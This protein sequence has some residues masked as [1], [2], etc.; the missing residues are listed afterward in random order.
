MGPSPPGGSGLCSHLGGR[1]WAFLSHLLFSHD[2]SVAPSHSLPLLC[3]GSLSLVLV[4]H[5]PA[6][7]LVLQASCPSISSLLT[8]CSALGGAPSAQLATPPDRPFALLGSSFQIQVLAP[9]PAS[10]ATSLKS[11][12]VYLVFLFSCVF[13]LLSSGRLSCPLGCERVAGKR[14]WKP[15]GE[16]SF[17]MGVLLWG[18]GVAKSL[19]MRTLKISVCESQPHG[20]A[21][22]VWCSHCLRSPG[23]IPGHRTTPPVCQ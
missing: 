19:L 9:A 12:G 1:H 21:V 14:N 4:L 20:L 16:G 23:L 13:G 2:V 6:L 18:D 15:R 7:T 10:S 17:S 11:R 8:F 22:K 5:F 3:L